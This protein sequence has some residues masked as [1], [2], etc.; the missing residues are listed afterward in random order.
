VGRFN[1]GMTNGNVAYWQR[2]VKY[3]LLKGGSSC[4]KKKRITFTHWALE[5]HLLFRLKNN[6][7]NVWK[8]DSAIYL[9]HFGL[10]FSISFLPISL[11]SWPVPLLTPVSDGLLPLGRLF[12]KTVMVAMTMLTKKMV[13]EQST[14]PETLPRHP[15]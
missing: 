11:H 7:G 6:L 4:I 9:P 14:H 8:N 12:G 13:T 5:N 2:F 1:V 10:F 3:L 15:T